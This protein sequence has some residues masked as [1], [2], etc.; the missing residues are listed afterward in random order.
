MPGEFRLEVGSL[1][2]VNNGL[3]GQLVDKRNDPGKLFLCFLPVVKGP[4][5]P[6]RIPHGLAVITVVRPSFFDLP[7]PL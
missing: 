1:V 2:L 3:F 5:P 7:D 4:E 6:Y